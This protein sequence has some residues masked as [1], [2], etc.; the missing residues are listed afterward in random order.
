M[1]KLRVHAAH[2]SRQVQRAETPD[3]LLQAGLLA[4][5]SVE[6]RYDPTRGKAESFVLQR[7]KLGM[8]DHLRS[9]FGR[10][11]TRANTVRLPR[12]LTVLLESGST[13]EPSTEICQATVI[14]DT[15]ERQRQQEMV[16]VEAER[17][18]ALI[19]EGMT[20]S[21]AAHRLGLT[22]HQ[23]QAMARYLGLRPPR[24]RTLHPAV[25]IGMRKYLK[26]SE[27][28]AEFRVA[29]VA[30]FLDG[31]ALVAKMKGEPLD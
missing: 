26:L 3:D 19:E 20:V 14:A 6:N 21:A 5:L 22:A 7:G 24:R 16:A 27:F 8:I 25:V 28:D 12:S 17:F 9:I 1:P 13:H 15:D 23:M 11:G 18:T 30:A 2:L 29:L 4:V 10:R 31:V